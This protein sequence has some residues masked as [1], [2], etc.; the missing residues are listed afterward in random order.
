METS[1][2][3][4][5]ELILKIILNVHNFIIFCTLFLNIPINWFIV[6]GKH[7]SSKFLNDLSLIIDRWLGWWQTILSWL[8]NLFQVLYKLSDRENLPSTVFFS[9]IK[10]LKLICLFF[11]YSKLFVQ[12]NCIAVKTGLGINILM[13]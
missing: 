5:L 7:T 2:F 10:I 6:L 11:Y 8:S 3:I 12:D 13:T 4:V 9:H 1:C